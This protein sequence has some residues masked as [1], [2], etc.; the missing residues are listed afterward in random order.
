MRTTLTLDDDVSARLEREQ[1]KRDVAFKQLVN[2]VLRAGLDALETKRPAR[3]PFVT[4]GFH[5]G[6]SLIGSLDDIEDVLSRIEGED[7]K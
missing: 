3:K 2:E 1:R 4:K 7:H 5:C 6:P